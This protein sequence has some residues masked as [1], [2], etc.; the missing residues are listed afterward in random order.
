MSKDNHS[1]SVHVAT[2]VGLKESI[3][4]AHILFMQKATAKNEGKWSENWVR[5]SVKSFNLT[6]PYLTPKE[7]KGATERLFDAGYICIKQDNTFAIDRTKSFLLTQKGLDLMGESDLTKSQMDDTKSQ[8]TFDKR[9]NADIDNSIVYP[10]KITNSA[11]AEKAKQAINENFKIKELFTQTRKVPQAKYEPYL[12]AWVGE[13]EGRQII[14]AN[15]SDLSSHFLNF[16]SKLF[17]KEKKE[18]AAPPAR[19]ANP[20]A[21]LK[22]YQ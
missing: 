4:L 19:P 1:F 3:I 14:Y 11:N 9:S 20:N 15:W 7:I 21:G 12:N 22:I 17:E 10:F 5:R 16:S 8:M 13:I 6:Y 2:E 18:Q